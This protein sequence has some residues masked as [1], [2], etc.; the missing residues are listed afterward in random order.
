[1]AR[2]K[3]R[4]DTWHRGL[5]PPDQLDWAT[6]AEIADVGA[7]EAAGTSGKVARGDHVH[8]LGIGT[9]KGDLLARSSSGWARLPVGADGQVLTADSAQAL[10][11]RWGTSGAGQA[12]NVGAIFDGGGAAISGTP[13]VDIQVPAAGTITG[14]TI[15]ADV[16]GSA[17]IDV[18]R[19]T[20]AGYPPTPSDS[21]VGSS[22]PTLASGVKA[23]GSPTG[24]STSLAA[25]DI[26]RFRVTSVSTVTRLAV[27]LNYT[28]S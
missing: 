26:L 21:I 8:A 16:T 20:Y 7:T 11:V 5:V 18:R 13:E 1:M 9:T 25:G 14:W 27:I 4:H 2:T 12:S 23:Q 10:G 15:L 24:W 19:T 6:T 17:T 28:R 3:H 22:P